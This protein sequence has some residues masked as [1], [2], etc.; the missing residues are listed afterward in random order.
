MVGSG[1]VITPADTHRCVSHIGIQHFTKHG[2]PCH[3]TRLMAGGRFGQIVG[4]AE[5]EGKALQPGAIPLFVA[6]HEQHRLGAGFLLGTLHTACD[7]VQRLLPGDWLK[8]IAAPGTHAAHRLLDTVFPIDILHGCHT[9]G[10]QLTAA[11]GE[12]GGAAHRGNFPLFHR[13]LQPAVQHRCADVT[14]RMLNHA[15]FS[16]S[17]MQA[18][19]A[20][21]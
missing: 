1:R 18:Q 20:F 15:S 2:A 13:Q 6:D 11:G 17:S 12:I 10:A 16:F 8:L 3:N 7:L 9:L 5:T 4:T 21:K 19:S 14:K